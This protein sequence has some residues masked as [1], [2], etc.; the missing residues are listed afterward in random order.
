[1]NGRI[2]RDYQ[3]E[4]HTIRGL[5]KMNMFLTVTFL[6]YMALVKSKVEK[7]ETEHLCRMY[8]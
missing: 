7:E 2:D 6:V 5:S 3:F 1:M 8:T 4:R